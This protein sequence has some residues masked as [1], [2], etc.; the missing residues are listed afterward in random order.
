MGLQGMWMK[1]H[2]NVESTT[3]TG[4]H[5]TCLFFDKHFKCEREMQIHTEGNH[6]EKKIGGNSSDK[7]SIISRGI[8]IDL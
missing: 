3:E 6:S 2:Q 1:P 4:G 5:F 8:L 7:S